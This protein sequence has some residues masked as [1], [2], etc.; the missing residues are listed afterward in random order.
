MS[1][2]ILRMVLSIVA[3]LMLSAAISAQESEAKK[4][5]TQTPKIAPVLGE[6]PAAA[7]PPEDL[8]A[9]FTAGPTPEWIWGA[10]N[11]KAYFLRTEFEG[12][13]ATAWLQVAC[14]NKATVWI[15]NQK[16]LQNDRWQAAD[17]AN[18]TAAIQPGGN[19]LTIRVENEGGNAGCIA[20]LVIKAADGAVRYVVTDGTWLAG[21]KRNSK[22]AVAVRTIGKL[23]IKPWGD[24]FN[25]SDVPSTPRDVF[26]LRPGF[27]VEK[28][29]TVPK[30][31]LG[32]WVA[33]TFDPKGRLIV[34]DQGDKGLCRITP[35]PIGSQEPT[36]V[37]RLDV[38]ISSA[39]GLLWAFDSLYVSVNGGIGSGLYRL[40]DTDSDDQFDDVVKLKEI[41][42]GGEHGPHAVR[43][44]PDRKSI[45]ICAGN[46]TL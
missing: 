31:E 19:T 38:K 5:Y 27:Q 14:D 43:L 26:V 3:V 22:D 7:K 4:L 41:R 35:P 36:K 24:P 21:V 12:P 16:V 11:N 6:T 46:H 10:D 2:A 23:G 33:M 34:S 17:L 15:N 44:S 39:Q 32:S 9:L 25:Q 30:D 20:K 29:F 28:L 45:Y 42:G 37:E 8:P 40:R 18:V 1:L 13:A